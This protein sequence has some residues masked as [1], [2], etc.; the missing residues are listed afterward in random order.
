MLLSLPIST[1][2]KVA[3][4]IE[5]YHIMPKDFFGAGTGKRFNITNNSKQ[6]RWDKYSPIPLNQFYRQMKSCSITAAYKFPSIVF[7]LQSHF[8]L[9][10]VLFNYCNCLS[11]LYLAFLAP[12]EGQL[13]L[14]K[15]YWANKIP[16][17]SYAISS[18]FN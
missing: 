6:P 7:L 18:S 2:I 15:K 3:I 9:L 10:F 11:H 14:T 1:T 12:D 4:Y 16:I 5:K 13:C 8:S 17:H